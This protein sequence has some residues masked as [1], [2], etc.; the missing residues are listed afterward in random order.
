MKILIS[1]DTS[2]IVK[3]GVFDG[4]DVSVFPL[5]VIVDGEEFLDGVTI[6]QDQLKEKMRSGSEIKTS[7]PPLGLIIEYFEEQFKKGYDHIIHFTISS[8][9][10]SMYSLFKNVAEQNFAGK[11]TV[12]DAYS[13]SAEMINYVFYALEQS[14]K[15]VSPEE[16][17]N[18]IEGLKG[19]SLIH[20]IPE[21]LTALKNGGRIS[22][23]IAL[24]GNT[25]GIKPVIILK[26][27]QLE[28]QE[29]TRR[30]KKY[31]AD[32][33]EE[34]SKTHSIQ[35][36]DYTI[37]SFDANE[38]SLEY[39]YEHA[40]AVLGEGNYLTG[41]LPI[42]VCAH[43]GPGTIGVIVTPKIDGKSLLEYVK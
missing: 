40:N 32:K 8:K 16:I 39:I 43:A 28:K 4:R 14:K 1:T 33:I 11:I 25:L 26:D 29:M 31:L 19:K 12:V 3:K 17:A 2:C 37:V 42:N 9:L 5:N 10:S 24:I 38:R 35:D 27:G 18:V 13:V 30:E 15:G 36:Y 23:A 34:L 21:N 6:D 41:I 22:P 7:T 20:F